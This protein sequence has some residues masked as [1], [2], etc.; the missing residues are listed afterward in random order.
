MR[1]FHRSLLLSSTFALS[2]ACL[3]A[4]CS[5]EEVKAKEGQACAVDADCETS[6]VCRSQVC[7]KVQTS[8][9]SNNT[10]PDMSADMT[11]MQ[12]PIEPERYMISF[13]RISDFGEEKDKKFLFVL[14]NQDNVAQKVSEDPLICELS[15]WPSRDLK[16]LVYLRQSTNQ[17]G[18][19]DVYV[20]SL[21]SAYKLQG[22]GTVA[23]EG[24]ERVDVVG[25]SIAFTRDENGV[26]KGYELKIGSTTE[27]LVGDLGAATATPG[28][29]AIN[30]VAQRAVLYK[31][32][33][34]LLEISI[35]SLGST[36]S[37]DP[38]YVLDASNYQDV[39]GSYF[40]STPSAFSPDGKYMAL[41]TR[42]PNNYNSCDSDV[43]CLGVGQHCGVK[44]FCTAIENTVHIFDLANLDK[45]GQNCDSDAK[46]GGVHQCYIPS[47]SALDQASCMPRRVVM[48]L[49]LTPAQPRNSPN[50]KGG[51]ENTAG[52]AKLPYTALTA[53][54]SFGADGSL[55]LVG[56]REC[57]G[58]N[59][60]LNIADTDIIKLKP[61]SSEFEV[62]YGNPGKNFDANLCY[63]ATENKVDVTNCITYIKSAQLSPGGNELT[64]LAT[65]PEVTDV[66]KA[67]SSYDVWT[68]LANGQDHEWN[69]KQDLFARVLSFWVHPKP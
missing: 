4:G 7:T 50:G 8:N 2:V 1:S 65:N 27:K 66:S 33:L 42:A 41:L 45:L 60:E 68:V 3:S 23:I 38:T 61:T 55:Y 16:S 31:P 24:A 25:N 10:D 36:I 48:G 40:S 39:G 30:D 46:C 28:S 63:D 64:F 18:T 9:N 37:G 47:N 17:P 5:D 52:N 62:V 57:A 14:D 53:P 69:G 15:C 21:D 67:A 11:D 49:P 59:G 44:K 6:L 22:N 54:M 26:K 35:G 13:V 29:I 51:C 20:A 34:Q 32:T 12:T 58:K 19:F 56:Q 43:D